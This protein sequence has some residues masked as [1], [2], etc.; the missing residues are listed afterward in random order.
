M[1]AV[2]TS[3]FQAYASHIMVDILFPL[4][5][6]ETC[7]IEVAT[8]EQSG[9]TQMAK[10]MIYPKRLTSTIGSIKPSLFATLMASVT[11]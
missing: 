11:K 1:Q 3:I 2:T 9:V 10:K 7:C 8:Q 5:L 4:C 6:D